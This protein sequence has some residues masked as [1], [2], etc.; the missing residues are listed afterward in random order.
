MGEAGAGRHG[1]PTAASPNGWAGQGLG[2]LVCFRG[3]H[4]PP[5]CSRSEPRDPARAVGRHPR[6][7]AA[8]NCGHTPAVLAG[9]TGHEAA[10][11]CGAWHASGC[12][13]GTRVGSY[14]QYW[15][16]AAW[17][18][19]EVRIAVLLSLQLLFDFLAF[20]NDIS[21]WKKKKSMIGMSTKAGG[22]SWA[23]GRCRGPSGGW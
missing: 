16:R 17:G 15:E 9:W 20:K 8:H 21:F 13:L 2:A 1:S 5:L 7:R 23:S 11:F 3:G 4:C 12:V 10:G 6:G 14:L 22:C 18:Q 19:G